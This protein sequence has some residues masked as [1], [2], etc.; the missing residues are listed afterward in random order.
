MWLLVVFAALWTAAWC[1]WWAIRYKASNIVAV[2]NGDVD[3][4]DY[5]LGREVE[6]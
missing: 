5:V 4:L 3:L 6:L 1:V 2:W